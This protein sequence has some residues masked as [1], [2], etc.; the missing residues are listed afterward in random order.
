MESRINVSSSI[1]SMK[2]LATT[3]FFPDLN[4]MDNGREKL[5]RKRGSERANSSQFVSL[6]SLPVHVLR[7]Q[8]NFMEKLF[9]KGEQNQFKNNVADSTPNSKNSDWVSFPLKE[10]LVEYSKSE[11]NIVVRKC[12]SCLW[13]YNINT[14]LIQ[15]RIW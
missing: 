4:S 9:L 5:R 2:I 13:L 6:F 3:K 15:Y 8:F 10:C 11:L 1:S 12:W 7:I 14:I